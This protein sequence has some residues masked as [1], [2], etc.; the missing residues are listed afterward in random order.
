MVRAVARKSTSKVFKTLP[1][2]SPPLRAEDS[3]LNAEHKGR[4][5]FRQNETY[6]TVEFEPHQCGSKCTED[7]PYMDGDYKSKLMALCRMNYVNF[8]CTRSN[9]E[10]FLCRTYFNS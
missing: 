6:Q 8:C 2:S 7:F 1:V 4:F 10:T 3:T 5:K 9:L